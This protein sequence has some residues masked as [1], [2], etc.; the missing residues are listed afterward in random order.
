VRVEGR[1]VARVTSKLVETKVATVIVILYRLA[2]VVPC[3]GRLEDDFLSG[4][5]LCQALC[6]IASPTLTSRGQDAHA[7]FRPVQG[8]SR[9]G[10]NH[11]RR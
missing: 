1:V 2:P 4:W 9:N 7:K 3:E 10:H 5:L 11:T 8:R 6:G